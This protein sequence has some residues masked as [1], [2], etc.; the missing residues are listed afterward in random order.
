MTNPAHFRHCRRVHCMQKQQF[1]NAR[2]HKT[3]VGVDTGFQARCWGLEFAG[4]FQQQLI[5]GFRIA[6]K[7]PRFVA[8]ERHF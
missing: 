7:Q 4:A 6:V 1:L 8:L 3:R 5:I 2:Q